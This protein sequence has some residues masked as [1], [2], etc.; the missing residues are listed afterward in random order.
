MQSRIAGSS[1]ARNSFHSVTIT[2]ASAPA[3]ASAGDETTIAP[4]ASTCAP[5]ATGS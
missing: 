5:D 4:T 2:A 1:T 3:S